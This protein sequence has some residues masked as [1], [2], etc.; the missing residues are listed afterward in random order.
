MRNSGIVAELNLRLVLI[1]ITILVLRMKISFDS[2]NRWRRRTDFNELGSQLLNQLVG[3]DHL[4]LARF[5]PDSN[6]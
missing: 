5:A 6:Q 3:L 1:F 2:R 4:S